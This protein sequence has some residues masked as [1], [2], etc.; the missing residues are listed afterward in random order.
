MKKDRTEKFYE[1]RHL[2]RSR[3]RELRQKQ[4]HKR[5]ALLGVT[6]AVVFLLSGTVLLG[7]WMKSSNAM[8]FFPAT[9][10]QT[11]AKSEEK[12]ASHDESVQYLSQDSRKSIAKRTQKVQVEGYSDTLNTFLTTN[13]DA[14]LYSKDSV[15]S[16]QVTV[17]PKGTTVETYG[18]EGDWTK[19]TSIG[20]T[21]YIRNENLDVVADASTFRVV[22][23]HV[24]VNALYSLSQDYETVFNDTASAALRVMLEAMER[25]GVPIEVATTYR[26]AADEARELVLSGN[27][28]HAPQP[29]HA[30]FQTGYAV[31]FNAPGTDP[32]MDNDFENT[33]Q[34]RWLHEHAEEYGY[35]LRY[36]KGSESITGYRADPTIF[37]YV[38]VQ[39]ASIISNEG[40]TME[41]FYGVE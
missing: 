14:V 3:R 4:R 19:V 24:I 12:A 35:I 38:G 9:G 16:Q 23:G 40:L 27:P 22:D 25:D 1:R 20:R 31:R 36:P 17:I 7:R 34:Y 26:S 2:E 13:K 6:L 30:V 28:E 29:G 10:S 41:V 37:Y 33:E 18:Y 11:E 8:N 39:D 5:N 15:K 21:G 32:R